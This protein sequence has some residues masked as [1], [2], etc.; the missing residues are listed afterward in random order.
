MDP[1]SIG[2][3][4]V[5]IGLQIF[6]GLG[7]SHDAERA[8]QIS[9]GIASDEQQINQQK[10]QQA[11]LEG[12]RMQLQQF[13][14]IQRQRALATAS[15]TSQGAQFGSGLQGG[16]AEVTNEGMFNAQG[17][18][19]NLQFASTIYGINNDISGKKMQMADVQASQATNQSLMSLGGSLTQ[20]AGTI[21]KLGQ[22]LSSGFGKLGSGFAGPYI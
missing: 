19:Q 14:N 3:G 16:L 1:L 12:S 22:N 7:A 4:I 20:N 18:N 15:A 8:A 17:I 9:R 21:G 10:Y 5:G 13:R 6:G 11:Q 2:A